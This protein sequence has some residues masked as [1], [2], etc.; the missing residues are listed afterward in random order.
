MITMVQE[1][2]KVE[3]EKEKEEKK[4]K[5][6]EM[7]RDNEKSCLNKRSRFLVGT[8]RSNKLYIS[9]FSK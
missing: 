3:K 2:K 6:E 4:K 9:Y 5:E 1:E 8:T 7:I